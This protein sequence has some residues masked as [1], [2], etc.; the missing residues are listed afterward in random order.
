MARLALRTP[1]AIVRLKDIKRA[2]LPMLA[3]PVAY[4]VRA[5]VTNDRVVGEDYGPIKGAGHLNLPDGVDGI[6]NPDTGLF[7][8]YDFSDALTGDWPYIRRMRIIIDYSGS[9]PD[10]RFVVPFL[11]KTPEELA[12]IAPDLDG[13]DGT[14]I[15]Y[16][17]FLKGIETPYHEGKAHGSWF[18]YSVQSP[19]GGTIKEIGKGVIIAATDGGDVVIDRGVAVIQD[20]LNPRRASLAGTKVLWHKSRLGNYLHEIPALN[21]TKGKRR[22][23]V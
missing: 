20:L 14:C 17:V 16:E 9:F 13:R 10:M 22:G 4:G 11:V 18:R 2:P 8:V 21:R 1:T 23:T 3:F 6:F 19:Q 12:R 5:F 7:T 15:P